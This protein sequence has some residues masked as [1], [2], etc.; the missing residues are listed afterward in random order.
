MDK[1]QPP[2]KKI[3]V[4]TADFL[5]L[6][7][8]LLP[9]DEFERWGESLRA[10]AA[11]ENGGHA[12]AVDEAWRSDVQ[13]LRAR[14]REIVDHPEILQALFIASPSLESSIGYWKRDPDSKK[15]R[16]T[17]RSLVRYFA[18]M[19][20]RPTPFGLFSR[21]SLGKVAKKGDVGRTDVVLPEMPQGFFLRSRREV[22]GFAKSTPR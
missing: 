12:A 2:G 18:R 14:L 11:W 6:R 3:D 8:P 17:E 22:T 9:F 10:R 13:L 16:Q 1:K 7:S 19:C 21:C 4:E 5:V 20:G 15:G